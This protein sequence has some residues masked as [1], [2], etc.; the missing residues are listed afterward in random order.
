[1]DYVKSPILKKVIYW[2][3]VKKILYN[4]SPMTKM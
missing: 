3:K 1:M 4:W 2:K